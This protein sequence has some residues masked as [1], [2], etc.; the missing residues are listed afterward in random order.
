MIC[1]N[2]VQ[3]G[4]AAKS[5]VSRLFCMRPVMKGKPAHIDIV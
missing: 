2:K 5:G 4:C 3:A 1:Y